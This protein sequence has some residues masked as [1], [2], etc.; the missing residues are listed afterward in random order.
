MEDKK[1]GDGFLEYVGQHWLRFV[2][3]TVTGSLTGLAAWNFTGSWLYVLAIIAMA[4][5]ASIYWSLRIED[6]GNKVQ[7]LAS[8]L[9][10]IVSWVAIIL[11]DLAS[12]T[13]IAGMSKLQI[14]TAFQQVPVWAQNT[15]VYVVP[16]LAVLHGVLATLHYYFSESASTK[17]AIKTT[18]REAQQ[19]IDKSHQA[20]LRELAKAQAQN[21][22]FGRAEDEWTRIA[23]TGTGSPSV[24]SVN[25][26]IPQSRK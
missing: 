21:I 2:A 1:Q 7:M 17:R 19:D 13:I 4:E 12:A 24:P 18:R 10:T 20:R 22:G 25:P 3:L 6:F 5:G 11:T 9:G 15:V 26:T 23:I 16:L 14:F 8:V